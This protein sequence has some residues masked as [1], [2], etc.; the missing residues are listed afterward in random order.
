VQE[1]SEARKP[2]KVKNKR[3]GKTVQYKN[4]K[5]QRIRNEEIEGK[6]KRKQT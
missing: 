1:T 5:R 2:H 3:E 4:V 6:Q